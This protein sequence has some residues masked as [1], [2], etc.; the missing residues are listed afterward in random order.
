MVETVETVERVERVER[1]EVETVERG[2]AREE[3]VA[4]RWTVLSAAVSRRIWG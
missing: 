4:I 3:R 2:V 1:V